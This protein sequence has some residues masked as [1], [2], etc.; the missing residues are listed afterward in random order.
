MQRLFRKMDS[1]FFNTLLPYLF[2]I[3]PTKVRKEVEMF[4]RIQ[5]VHWVFPSERNSNYFKA[6]S[7]KIQAQQRYYLEA[8]VSQHNRNQTN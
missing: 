5:F 4:T 3:A 7:L 1:L 6:V 8:P 2:I